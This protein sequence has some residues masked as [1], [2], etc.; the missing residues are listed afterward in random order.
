MFIADQD[1]HKYV[2]NNY[3]RTRCLFE[4]S[5]HFLEK[6]D[7]DEEREGGGGYIPPH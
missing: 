7:G 6:I 5:Y 4:E 3:Y 2:I 1:T